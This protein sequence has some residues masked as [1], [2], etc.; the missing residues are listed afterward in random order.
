MTETVTG[1]LRNFVVQNF[2]FG[3]LTRPL[4]DDDSFLEKG[5]VDSTGILEMVGFLEKEFDLKVQDEEIVPDH[6]DSI[7][8]LARYVHRKQ[9]SV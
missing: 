7:A 9:G 2:L 3:D 6:F 4:S 8:R 5:I 1:T